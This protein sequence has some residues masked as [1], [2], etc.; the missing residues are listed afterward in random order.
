MHKTLSSRSKHFELHALAE[1][2][3]AATAKDGGSAICNAG[4]IDLGGQILAFDTFMTPQAALDLRQFAI[5]VF[6]RIPQIVINSHY[7]ND[8]IWGNQ[9]FTADAQIISS[10]RTRELIATAGME[11]FQWYSANSAQR[12]EALHVQ[13]QNAKDEE[14]QKPLL[15]WIGYY[16]GLVEAL[17][18]LKVCM[19]SITFDSCLEMHGAKRTAR[20]VTFEGAHTGSDTILHL[21]QEGMLFMSDLLFVRC[22]P[23]LA[24]GDPLRLLNALRELS[25]L[26]ASCLVPGHGPVG[27]SDDLLLL[28]EYIEQCLDTAQMLVDTGNDHEER[29]GELKIPNMCQDWQQPQFYQTNIDFLCKSLSS[30]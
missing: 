23:Y 28:I 5:D 30:A 3:F 15:S 4:L 14:Q 1:G 11:E 17:P 29:I 8:H 21:P 13:Y 10:S 7:H 18:H 19:P 27:T 25:L 26:N 12:L 16:A 24:D 9:V 20:L 2:I 22:H 6:T